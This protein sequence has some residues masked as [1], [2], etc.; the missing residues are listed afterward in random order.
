MH[1]NT[2][3]PDG[4]TYEGIVVH[5]SKTLIIMNDVTDFT[6][7]GIVCLPKKNITGY[8]DGDFE[9]CANNIL[10]FTNEISHLITYPWFEHVTTLY[11]LLIQLKKLNIWPAVE[12]VIDDESWLFIGKLTEV[13]K[14]HIKMVSYSAG[15]VWEDE[16]TIDYAYIF[17][18]MFN[19]KY[20]NI[21]NAYMKSQNS[22]TVDYKL[23]GLKNGMCEDV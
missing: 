10:R 22:L 7:D 8:R 16:M 12:T 18:V 23:M 4:D 2:N 13:T 5:M 3:H 20:V 14:E 17:K 9:A 15:G 6:I 1:F 19:S 11:S 21:F